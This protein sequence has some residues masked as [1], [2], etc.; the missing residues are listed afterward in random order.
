MAMRRFCAQ[1]S[2]VM[3]GRAQQREAMAAAKAVPASALASVAN[4][5]ATMK[6]VTIKTY[7]AK[8]PFLYVINMRYAIRQIFLVIAAFLASRLR[9]DTIRQ[10][11]LQLC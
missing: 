3:P 5:E 6:G 9:G 8:S 11:Y 2:P 10:E 7:E 4:V 1:R